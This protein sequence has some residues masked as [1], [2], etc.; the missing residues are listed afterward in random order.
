LRGILKDICIGVLAG[1]I[2]NLI[3]IYLPPLLPELWKMQIPTLT[4]PYW[5]LPP[6]TFSV[7]FIVSARIFRARK[8]S[9]RVFIG[10]GRQR[11]KIVEAEGHIDA[12]GVRWKI[13]LGYSGYL[14]L[15]DEF[16]VYV[17]GPF[18]PTCDYELDIREKPKLFGWLT[19]KVWHCASCSQDYN[20]PS[21]YLYDEEETV[22]KIVEADYRRREKQRK[23]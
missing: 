18:C 12:F 4:W 1:F 16:Q 19:R 22:G 15:K 17:D 13:I 7:L 11:P 2:T 10:F 23:K 9:R 14:R 3:W 20:R 21:K 6:V 5:T 8:R